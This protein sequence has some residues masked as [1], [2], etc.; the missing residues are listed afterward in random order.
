MRHR[1]SGR[2]KQPEQ[3]SS[4]GDVQEYDCFPG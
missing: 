3:F 4:Q 2:K 1:K